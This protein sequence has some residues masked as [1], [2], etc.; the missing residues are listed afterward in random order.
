[1]MPS[2]Y[3]KDTLP[4]PKDPRIKIVEV[5]PRT[6]AAIRYSWG[7]GDKK[8]AEKGRELL[9]WLDTMPEY[10]ANAPLMSAG[11]DPPWTIPFLRRN[12]V[13]VDVEGPAE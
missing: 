5:P 9:A 2:K 1:M 11:Y 6:V 3:K 8:N 10:R 7:R 4:L 12:E 13:L